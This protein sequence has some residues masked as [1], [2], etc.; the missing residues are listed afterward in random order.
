MVDNTQEEKSKSPTQLEMEPNLIVHYML[1]DTIPTP[2]PP[3]FVGI[4][5]TILLCT[6]FIHNM[7]RKRVLEEIRWGF[8][9][10]TCSQQF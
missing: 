3:T 2:S 1:K 5:V 6:K 7:Q 10:T 9:L 8:S 4:I